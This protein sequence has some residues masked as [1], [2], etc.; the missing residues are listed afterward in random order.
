MCSS[1]LIFGDGSQTRTFCF[2]DDHLDATTKAFYQNELVN[3][4]GNIG[5]D[6]EHSVMDVARLLVARMTTDGDV[7]SHVVFVPDR[8]FNDFRYSVD[9]SR[10]R[11]LGW[12]EE[13]T[14]FVANIES[15]IRSD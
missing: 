3:D 7:A 4:V 12:S 14:D 2:I 10:L 11:E 1:D 8:P 6:Q 13:H 9:S 15:L 5:T